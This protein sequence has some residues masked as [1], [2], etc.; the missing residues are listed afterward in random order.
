LNKKKKNDIT[1]DERKKQTKQEKNKNKHFDGNIGKEEGKKKQKTC[2]HQSR[3][4][5]DRATKRGICSETQMD[6]HPH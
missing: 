2:V 3:S 5:E 1:K 4:A 6:Q